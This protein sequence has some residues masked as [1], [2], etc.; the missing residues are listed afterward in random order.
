MGTQDPDR[1]DTDEEPLDLTDPALV[2]DPFTAYAHIRA[3]KRMVRGSVPGVD[4]MWVATRYDD[5]RAVMS[6][7]R[8]TI[9]AT[10]VPGAPV[11]HRTEQTWQARGMHRGYEKYLRA[12]I[13]DADGADHRRLRG[14]VGAAFSPRRVTGLRP[15]IETVATGLLD[16]L[17]DH[18]EDGVVDLIEHYAR[19]LPITVICELIAVP[20]ADRDR[21]RARS[22]TLVAGVCGDELGDALAGMVDDA[23]T[24]VDHHTAHPGDDLISDLLDPRHRDRLSPEELVA[25]IVN[26]VVA[27][28]ITTVNLIANG[29]EALLTH[30]GQLALL[31]DDPTL[32][33]HA[34]DELMRYCGPVVRALPRYA[35]CDTT[36]GA[37]PVKAGEAVLPIVS[38]ANRDP[39]A[40]T[41][42]DR[43]DLGR[44]R[45]LR[46]HHLGFGHGAHRCLG[47]HLAHEE[48]VIALTTLLDRAP[49]LRLAV[50][51][52][53]LEHGTNPVNRHL[54]ALPVRW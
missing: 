41:D 7:P 44:T 15:R 13:F 18:A 37:T 30:P 51:P 14:L 24:L 4:P 35:L 16:R 19:P 21:W 48:A 42:P 54:K 28:H 50:D 33:P 43:L 53:R 27:G 32:M 39:A 46:E 10:G 26:L 25:L 31:R 23:I 6:D 52:R 29:T 45:R 34:V 1:A 9:D 20:E 3:R 36:L 2:E 40:F 11:A 22:A 38:A 5:I 47:A 12:G 17:P 8:F 49:E